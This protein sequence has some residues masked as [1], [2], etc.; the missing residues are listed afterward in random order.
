MAGTAKV[1][2]T[3]KMTKREYKNLHRWVRYHLGRPK[4]C[5]NCGDT[6]NRV[7]QWANI[8]G[9]YKRDLN[10]WERLCVPC[11]YRKDKNLRRG[12]NECKNG[13]LMIGDNLY[14]HPKRGDR[15]CRIG[16]KQ[17]INAWIANNKGE[18]K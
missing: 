13:H 9:E 11:H 16:K 17:A 3:G 18:S 14:V 5:K 6:S 8:S 4:L 1:I 2:A 15:E 10:D 12:P 7:Y